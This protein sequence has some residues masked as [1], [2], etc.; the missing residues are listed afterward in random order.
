VAQ[1][2]H[3]FRLFLEAG[4]ELRDA[5][6]RR[7]Q[8]LHGGAEVSTFADF[9]DEAHAAPAQDPMHHPPGAGQAFAHAK[10]GR[11]CRRHHPSLR[12]GW[13]TG[14]AAGSLFG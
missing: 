2:R 8:D 3:H 12:T 6:G 14:W 1:A 11:S 4:F 7:T 13:R 10:L 5:P 9:E